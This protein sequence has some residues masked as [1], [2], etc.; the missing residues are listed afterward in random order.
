MAK[1]RYKIPTSLDASYLDVEFLLQNKDGLGPS[2]PVNGKA[3]VTGLVS[4]VLWMFLIFKTPV[5][6]G[7]IFPAVGFTITWFALSILL[8]LPDKTN[9]LG[10]ELI[11][12][13]IGY[14]PKK[15]RTVEVRLHNDVTKIQSSTGVDY[16]DVEDG[17][18]H[19]LDGTVGRV[20]H[21]VG[22]ASILMFDADKT[23]ILDKVDNFYRKLP[24]GVEVIF[25]TVKEAQRTDIQS[26]AAIEGYKN[27]KKKSKG[28]QALYKER[29]QVL[30]YGVG[31]RFKSI[32][33]YAIIK[34]PKEESLNEGESLIQGDVEG[35]GLMFKRAESLQ[36]ED[37][38]RYTKQLFGE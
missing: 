5:G 20:Y 24:V 31:E 10:F 16:V 9:R 19:F 37:V 2:K 6:L 25:D 7:G 36:Y 35:E 33:Q 28:L 30:K 27:L 1:Q 23:M 14:L 12:S 11:A 3:I 18:I 13:M 21:V 22:S 26:K 8:V 32:H 15:A 29:H 4:I 38:I 17:M 34:G